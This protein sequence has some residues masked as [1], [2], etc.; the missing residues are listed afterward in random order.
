MLI[1]GNEEEKLIL[2]ATSRN[3]LYKNLV[4][5]NFLYMI[6]SR[7]LMDFKL[8]AIFHV[9][10]TRRKNCL[11]RILILLF[12]RMFGIISWYKANPYDHI[13]SKSF[14]NS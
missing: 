2:D 9:K 6:P 10:E 8:L 13:D 4:E 7:M 12:P 14:R 1:A 3:R 11:I 5:I